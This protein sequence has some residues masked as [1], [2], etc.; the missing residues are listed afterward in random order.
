MSRSHTEEHVVGTLQRF[1]TY[2]IIESDMTPE[3]FSDQTGMWT[4]AYYRLM[5][6]NER[7]EV[8]SPRTVYAIWDALDLPKPGVTMDVM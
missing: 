2:H 8:L 6:A 7:G 1:I 3:Q 4:E 5:G